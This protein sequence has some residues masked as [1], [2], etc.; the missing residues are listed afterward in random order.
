MCSLRIFT[1]GSRKK[2]RRR[3]NERRKHVHL[4]A[5]AFVLFGIQKATSKY[6]L[7]EIKQ[8]HLYIRTSIDIMTIREL[9]GMPTTMEM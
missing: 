3:R 4:F 7:A 1:L 6:T 8:T 2:R 5:N 9:I